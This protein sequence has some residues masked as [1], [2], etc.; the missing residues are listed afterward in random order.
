MIISKVINSLKSILL[1]S[2]TFCHSMASAD[3]QSSDSL[4]SRI[5]LFEAWLSTLMDEQSLVGV[6][7]SLVHDQKLVYSKGFGFADF[8]N[9]YPA[10][11]ETNYRVASITKLFTSIALMQLV[12]EQKINLSTDVA[13]IVPE[14]RKI[15]SNEYQVNEITIKSILTHTTGLPTNPYFVLDEKEENVKRRSDEFLKNLP[16]QSIIFQPNRSS[17]YSNL[18]MDLGGVIIERISGLPYDQYVQEFILKP[19]KMKSSGFPFPGELDDSNVIG[20]NRIVKNKRSKNKFSEMS[21]IL[22]LPAAGLVSN[23]TDLAKFMSWHFSVLNGENESL[24]SKNQ[25]YQM[26]KIHWVGIPIER[27]PVLN[28]AMSYIANSLELGGI[29]LGYFRDNEFV[30][31][32]GG[33]SGFSSKVAMNNT[34]KIGVAVLANSSDAPVSFEAPRSISRNLYQMIGETITEDGSISKPMLYSEYEALYSNDNFW[35]FYAIEMNQKLVLIDLLHTSPMEESIVLSEVG[36]DNF[37]NHDQEGIYK[38]EFWVRFHRDK[39]G[40]VDSIIINNE[41]IYRREVRN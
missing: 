28:S 10:T 9:R 40:T 41:K 2:F 11:K 12:E 8:E 37:V 18:A 25:L 5:R 14:L 3:L 31:H 32:G 17:K 6:S 39:K 35:Y 21:N 23:V 1:I 36:D 38:G 24:L 19:L 13:N 30:F 4:Q 29:G 34:K 22:G 16:Q 27:H 15:Q 26:Q 7:V 33:L 20:Y